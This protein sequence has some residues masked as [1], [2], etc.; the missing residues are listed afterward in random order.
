MN[1]AVLR[2]PG[3]RLPGIHRFRR[4]FWTIGI[5]PQSMDSI[6]AHGLRA[7]PRW[8]SPAAN[9]F[10]AD[11]FGLVLPDGRRCVYAER[12]CYSGEGA[13]NG[14]GDIVMACLDADEAAQDGGE[15]DGKGAWGGGTPAPLHAALNAGRFRPSVTLPHHLSY[16]SLLECDGRWLLFAE[17]SESN[18]LVCFTADSPDGPWGDRRRLMPGTP[19]IDPTVIAHEGLWYLFC[20]HRGD[21]PQS[22][23][24]LYTADHPLGPWRAHPASPVKT[25]RGSARPAGPVFRGADGHLYR[26]GQDCRH[27]YGGAVMIHRIDRLT[28]EEFAETPVRHLAPVPGPW[29]HGLHTICAFGDETLIDGKGYRWS[30]TEPLDNPRRQ[31]REKA[32]WQATLQQGGH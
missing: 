4:E 11:P 10:L 32:R 15:G 22:R 17:C 5:V 26:P 16:P 29:G 12:L 19:V 9:T 25:D 14:K 13:H 2:L 21:Q 8:L 6:I 1:R 28:P 31:R 18:G 30:I 3:P 20:T 7:E 23:L 27:T 24:Q